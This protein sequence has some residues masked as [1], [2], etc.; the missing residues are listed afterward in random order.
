MKQSITLAFEST[1][2]LV[3]VS[4]FGSWKREAEYYNA[5]ANAGEA[6]S[7]FSSKFR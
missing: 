4:Q 2:A 6:G 5:A 7:T 1:M 3:Q